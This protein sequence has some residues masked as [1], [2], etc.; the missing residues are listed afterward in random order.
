MAKK[1]SD[2][3]Y[4]VHTPERRKSKRLCHINMLKKYV[5]RDSSLECCVGLVT[6]V[7]IPDAANEQL[8]SEDS[9]ENLN[10][11]DI[12]INSKML[13]SPRL[14]NSDIL[15]NLDSKLGHLNPEERDQMAQLIIDCK[16]L[17]LN[18]SSKTD[19]IFHDVDI[20]D[21]MPI[22]QHPYR[23]SPVKK[24]CLKEEIKYLL[25][26]D[27]IKPSNSDWSSP[28]ILVPEPY[29]AYRLCTDYRKV[30]GVTKT[31]S[32]PIPRIDDC[33][34]KIGKAKYVTKFN[35]LKGFWQIPLTDNA[36]EVSAFVTP[37][38]LF[39][40]NVMPFGMKNSLATFQRLINM[41][42]AEMDGIGAYIDDVIIYSDF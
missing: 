17:F 21:S 27:F 40:Y 1:I 42:I 12:Q 26:N 39:R 23:M 28:C 31:D 29:G 33:I 3:N 34:E 10:D 25:V 7:S 38:G 13:S 30:N 4:I 32:S 16:H 8:I 22:K 5:N 11:P 20:G 41:W 36:K 15:N 37:D 19:K 6:L 14:N 2:V 18:V 9:I 24:E 35:L